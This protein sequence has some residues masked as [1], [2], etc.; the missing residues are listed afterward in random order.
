[1]ARKA[2]T[3][4]PVNEAPII[5]GEQIGDSHLYRRFQGTDE[6][7]PIYVPAQSDARAVHNAQEAAA[8]HGLRSVTV[9]DATYIQFGSEWYVWGGG[10]FNRR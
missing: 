8:K 2:A 6:V 5:I 3:T 7:S 10:A 1:M 4:A 9:Y